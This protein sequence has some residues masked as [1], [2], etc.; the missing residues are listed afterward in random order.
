M[1]PLNDRFLF[2]VAGRIFGTPLMMSSGKP[3]DIMDFMGPRLYG[4]PLH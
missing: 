1:S 4:V 3:A 2:H